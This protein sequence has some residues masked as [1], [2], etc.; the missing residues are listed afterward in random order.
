M[1]R[2]T[3]LGYDH[4]V[5]VRGPPWKRF[6]EK[7]RISSSFL[8]FHSSQLHYERIIVIIIIIVIAWFHRGMNAR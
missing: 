6:S 8:L 3:V 1:I 2:D 5:S 4:E 7:L